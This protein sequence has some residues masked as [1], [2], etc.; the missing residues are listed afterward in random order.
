MAKLRVV[1]EVNV[2][3]WG[4]AMDEAFCNNEYGLPSF[5]ILVS[6]YVSW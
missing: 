5:L 1:G 4:G 6:F 3:V 2:C